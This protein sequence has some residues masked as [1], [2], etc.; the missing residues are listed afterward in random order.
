MLKLKT[1]SRGNLSAVYRNQNDLF[2]NQIIWFDIW[3]IS[4]NQKKKKKLFIKKSQY[5]LQ[6]FTFCATT[7]KIDKYIL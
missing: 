2:M 6:K 3:V 5:I 1:N 4:E 7:G